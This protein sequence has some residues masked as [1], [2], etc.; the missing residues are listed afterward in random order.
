L[1]TPEVDSDFETGQ[2]PP[3]VA[4]FFAGAVV[5]ELVV[6][7]ASLVIVVVD[8]VEAVEAS[9]EAEELRVILFRWG[10]NI[11]ETSSEL[12]AE[13]PPPVLPPFQP[14]LGSA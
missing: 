2:K 3:L 8:D 6:G 7:G 4:F 13:N 10:I 1:L 14:S 5:S 9:D 11:L 12:M